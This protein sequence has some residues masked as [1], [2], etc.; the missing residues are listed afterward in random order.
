[1]SDVLRHVIRY[2]EKDKLPDIESL[3]A[4]YSDKDEQTQIA[5]ASALNLGAQ[6]RGITIPT[7]IRQW[8]VRIVRPLLASKDVTQIQRGIELASQMRL[9]EVAPAIAPLCVLETPHPAVRIPALQAMMA[10]NPEELVPLFFAIV[11]DAND[12]PALRR[13]IAEK[14]A[15]RREPALRQRVL[16]MLP[17]A[18][19]TVAVGLGQGLII[20]REGAVALLDLVEQGKVSR[21]VLQNGKIQ[22]LLPLV[23]P[24]EDV[25]RMK[26]LV[27]DLP[28]LDT[29]VEQA[30]AEHRQAFRKGEPDASRGAEIF[31]KTCAVCHRLENDG[32]KVGP[33]LD[34]IGQRGV[35]RLLE[36]ILDPN[37]TVD[38]TYRATIVL[39]QDGRVHTGL[40]TG[41]EGQILLLAD[42]TGKVQR[43]PLSEIDQ[44]RLIE[45][46][47]MP[48]NVSELLKP[49][50]I[51]DLL[52]FLLT[53]AVKSQA[54]A[55][56]AVD[57]R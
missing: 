38:K 56:R 31:R 40:V 3:V 2:I 10:I 33:E 5:V 1:M 15:N 53:K 36:D 16:E 19:Q 12:L 29:R 37:R 17:S 14:L 30:I 24:P 6:E 28:S 20:D 50:E 51:H 11:N 34:G 47:A 41:Q 23:S 55:E 44:R 32:A 27:A 22:R 35:D 57:G 21:Q 45:G 46:S 13:L 39:M 8:G 49:K 43:I 26:A 48:A 18:S 25:A 4:T 42:Q 54:G 9:T 52:A 7:S